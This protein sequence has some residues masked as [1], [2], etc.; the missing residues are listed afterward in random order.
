MDDR[1]GGHSY[2]RQQT[3]FFERAPERLARF[4]SC[5]RGGALNPAGLD[6]GRSNRQDLTGA[7]S[8]TNGTLRRGGTTAQIAVLSL[9][10]AG[11]EVRTRRPLQ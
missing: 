11:G 7:K 4:V 9:R 10:V 2:R 1:I 8:S 6:A 3:G 5:N